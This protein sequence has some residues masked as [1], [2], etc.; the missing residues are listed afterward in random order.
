MTKDGA[1]LAL[2]DVALFCP[3]PVQVLSPRRGR[4]HKAQGASPEEA[5]ARPLP[6]PERP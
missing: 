3:A 2:L 6:P 5:T 4:N 1:S